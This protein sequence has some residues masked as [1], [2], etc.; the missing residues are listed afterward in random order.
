M[1]TPLLDVQ[2]LVKTYDT[3]GDEPLTVL[4]RLSLTVQPGEIVAVVGESGTGKSTLLHLLGALERPTGGTVQFQGTDLFSKTDEELAAFRNRSIGFVFQFHHLLPEFTALE[5]VAMPALIRRQSMGQAQG[6]AR[7]LLALLG[8]EA[9]AEHQPSALSGGEKQRVAVARALMNEPDLVLMD[10]PTG[11]LDARTAEPLHREIER[12]RRER[13]HTF[14]LATHNPALARIAE[15][16]L[17]LEHGGLH[18]VDATEAIELT[19][20]TSD[21]T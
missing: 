14:I 15:R 9:R 10:E 6:R 7:E 16:V 5:N 4:D 18:P 1:A 12:L 21:S 2:D 11:N 17:R 20:N 19:G 13:G 3:G 8:L